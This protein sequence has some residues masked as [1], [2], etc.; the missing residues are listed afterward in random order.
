MVPVSCWVCS[1]LPESSAA[2][3]DVNLGKELNAESKIWF[4]L[5]MVKVKLEWDDEETLSYATGSRL[6]G[7]NSPEC[8]NGSSHFAMGGAKTLEIKWKGPVP[9]TVC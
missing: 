2:R 4:G 5:M 3:S 7:K 8:S 9:G 1:L 6:R